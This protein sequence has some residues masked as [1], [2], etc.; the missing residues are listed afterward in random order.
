ML[1]NS[2]P[3]R[4]SKNKLLS[5]IISFVSPSK[6]SDTKFSKIWNIFFIIC[7]MLAVL[8]QNKGIELLINLMMPTIETIFIFTA[9]N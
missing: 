1:I 6:L 5:I 7:S 8:S 9:E 4:N 3:V 2:D